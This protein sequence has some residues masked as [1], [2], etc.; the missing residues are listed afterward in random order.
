V[1]VVVRLYRLNSTGTKL[2]GRL[3]VAEGRVSFSIDD[4]EARPF[5]E[6]LE[7]DGIASSVL[8]RWV[9]PE[10]G[11]LFLDAVVDSLRT[12]SYW[13]AERDTDAVAASGAWLS[14]RWKPTTTFSQNF[15]ETGAG[16]LTS[17]SHAKPP[18]SVE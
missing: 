1:A 18:H 10:D 13:V 14:Q 8:K 6:E 7:R 16:V 12:T 11:E 5:F 4:P 3:I 15:F 17:N 9:G 2:A